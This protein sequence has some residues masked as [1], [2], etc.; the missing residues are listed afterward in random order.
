MTSNAEHLKGELWKKIKTSVFS[1]IIVNLVTY[2]RLSYYRRV[3]RERRGEVYPAL[4][5]NL[6][7]NALILGKSTLI[8]AIF[9]LNFLLKM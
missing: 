9:E 4:S 2:S 6:E 8:V 7:K 1:F 5:Q 3:D